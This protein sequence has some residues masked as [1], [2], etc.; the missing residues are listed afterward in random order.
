V[1]NLVVFNGGLMR[2]QSAHWKLKKA[3]FVE[4]VQTAPRYR[5]FSIGD[6]YPAM[7]RDEARGVSLAAELYQVS[8][9][10]WPFIANIE[11]PGL[12]RGP[13]ELSDGRVVE[14]MLGQERFVSRNGTDI[15]SSGGWAHYPYR[16]AGVRT[17]RDPSELTFD[18]F[19]NGTLMR[20]LKLHENLKHA[21]YLGT[22][23]TEPHY[24]LHSINDVHPGMYRLNPGERGGISVP[25]ELYRISHSQ[26][27]A[28]EASEPPNLY[29]G[30]VL[31]EDMT[32]VFG[33][34]YPREL[35]EGRHLDITAH[36]GWREYMAARN[37]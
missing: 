10:A 13:V 9:E 20:G 23:R 26:W 14:G 7:V 15:S 37:R 32:E 1:G 5:L 19:V 36:G 21:P 34:L 35:A 33:I 27:A 4:A 29:R 25:G 11:A 31:L 18:L 16:S 2:G 8:E 6:R 30:R 28:L 24:R 3:V 22:Y 17:D 12:Y